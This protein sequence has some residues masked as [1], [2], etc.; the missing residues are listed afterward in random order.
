MPNKLV[1]DETGKRFFETGVSRGILFVQDNTGSYGAGVAWNG[2]T[3]VNH[4]PDGG[5][6]TDFWADNIK[7][8]SIRSAETFGGSIEAY[9]YPDEFAECDGSAEA[10]DNGTA[11]P[12]VYF[13][14]QARKRFGFAYRSQIGSDTQD[15]NED[16]AP[17]KLHL[18]YNASVNPSERAYSTIN[19]SP[20]AAT[21]SWDFDTTGVVVEGYKPVAHIEIDSRKFTDET[22]KGYLQALINILEGSSTADAELPT[23]TEVVHILATGKKTGE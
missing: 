4:S 1:W 22:K 7:Y 6:L 5:E 8:A 19:D 11:V 20:D 14:Q 3:A 15:P 23:P 21:L 13:G 2:L 18:I 12:G 17:F 16:G 9:T 10:K